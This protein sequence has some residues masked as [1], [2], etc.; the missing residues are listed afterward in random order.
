MNENKNEMELIEESKEALVEAVEKED[1]S[2]AKV[3]LV[4]G[5]VCVTLVGAGYGVY[6]FVK[7]KKLNK[8][9]DQAFEDET[10]SEDV[11]VES[12]E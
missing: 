1:C 6:R 8:A 10:K 9:A 2:V 3:I 11:D 7:S 4:G 5:L 12:E